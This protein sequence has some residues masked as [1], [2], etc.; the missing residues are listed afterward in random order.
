[1]T[2]FL[3]YFLVERSKEIML[4]DFGIFMSLVCLLVSVIIV[5]NARWVIHC[6]DNSKDLENKMVNKIKVLAALVSIVSLY[7][8]TILIK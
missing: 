8:V 4:R 3:Y 2:V 6:I 5:L 7:I 1:M